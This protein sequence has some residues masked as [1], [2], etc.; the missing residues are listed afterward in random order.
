MVACHELCGRGASSFISIFPLSRTNISTDNSH[1]THIDSVIFIAISFAFSDI[2]LSILQGVIV[3]LRI[4]FSCIFSAGSNAIIS[5]L[6][7]LQ[8]MTEISILKSI[9]FS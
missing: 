9:I 7:L 3:V 5:P 6:F 2:F 8:T 1:S 4:Q